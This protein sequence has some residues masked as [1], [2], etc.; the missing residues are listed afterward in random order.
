MKVEQSPDGKQKVRG[1]STY[2]AGG[3]AGGEAKKVNRMIT[4]AIS[5]MGMIIQNLRVL[6]ISMK[7]CRVKRI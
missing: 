4:A 5:K 1:K 7:T 6:D 2:P 3:Y